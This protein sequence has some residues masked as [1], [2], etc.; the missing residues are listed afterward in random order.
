M[1]SEIWSAAA[2]ATAIWII[3]SFTVISTAPKPARPDG[4]VWTLASSDKVASHPTLVRRSL[5]ATPVS[6]RAASLNQ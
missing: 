1:S 3:A 5:A 6:W 2:A 4:V